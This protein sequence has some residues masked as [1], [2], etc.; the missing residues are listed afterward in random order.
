M[1]KVTPRWALWSGV[2]LMLLGLTAMTAAG[3]FLLMLAQV[4]AHI[5]G[6][7]YGFQIYVLLAGVGIGVAAF[8]VGW[9]LTQV[10]R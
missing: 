4:S 9:A 3:M 5:F 10:K 2:S 8:V 7:S 1:Q 6:P